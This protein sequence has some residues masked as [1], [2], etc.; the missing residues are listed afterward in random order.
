MGMALEDAEDIYG[1]KEPVCIVSDSQFTLHHVTSPQ[2]K[3]HCRFIQRVREVAGRFA[4]LAFRYA[5]A[6]C[7]V[8]G[9]EKADAAAK[10]GAE[11]S[12]EAVRFG[13]TLPDLPP[14][15]Q[16]A[17]LPAD[18]N[19]IIDSPPGVVEQFPNANSDSDFEAENS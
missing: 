19:V 7:G 15:F 4:C 5:P 14:Y 8:K 13:Y 12:R 9:N 2:Y 10:A 16:D 1:L 3:G 6:H 17:P 18:E 11:L